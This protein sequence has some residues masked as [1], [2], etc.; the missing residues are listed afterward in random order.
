[1]FTTIQVLCYRLVRNVGAGRIR[2]GLVL[3]YVP[4]VI[5]MPPLY[6]F[7]VHVL[8]S[9]KLLLLQL[10]SCCFKGMALSL[11]KVMTRIHL[12]SAFLLNEHYD[13]CNNQKCEEC[14]VIVLIF[15][16]LKKASQ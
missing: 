8:Q 12:G 2:R 5:T 14:S 11:V 7:L 16:G 10:A 9:F 4:P 6:V 3:E 13:C 15:L 1:M